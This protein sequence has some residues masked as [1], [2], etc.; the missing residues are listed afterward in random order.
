M[1]VVEPDPWDKQQA[2]KEGGVITPADPFGGAAKFT[3]N[4]ASITPEEWRYPLPGAKVI[5][6]FG[7][8]GGRRHSG[9]DL[10][11]KAGDN[12]L[13]AFDGVVIMS[14]VFSGY[15]NCVIV[16]HATGLETLYS[17]NVKNLVKVGQQVKAGQVI[18][19][20][21]RTGRAT[22]EHLHFECRV[23][24]KPFNPNLIFNHTTQKLNSHK[25]TFSKNGA[26]KV[27]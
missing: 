24:G 5:S 21:G 13:A 10:K 26:V 2:S 20:T 3:L 17:H 12:I 11:T 15:G 7:A 27:N 22:T 19:L 14:Q 4:L 16:R 1:S 9:V 8:R 6:P 18:A 23:N 25:L